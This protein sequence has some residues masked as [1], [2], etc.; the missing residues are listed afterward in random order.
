MKY[1][2]YPSMYE[3][4]DAG[5]VWISSRPCKNR[6]VVRITNVSN[7]C[8][9]FCEALEIDQGFLNRYNQS[10][11]CTIQNSGKSLVISEWYRNRLDV[12]KGTEADLEV[13]AP[14]GLVAGRVARL[15]CCLQHPQTVVQI[16][17]W[18]GIISFIL[19]VV[20]CILGAMS[21]RGCF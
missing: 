19:G 12:Q 13:V 5:W 20:G 6:C 10:P 7:G 11:R 3:D 21:L 4:I 14:K 18:L 2:I 16:S 15:L 8:R 17:T 1:M 9:T